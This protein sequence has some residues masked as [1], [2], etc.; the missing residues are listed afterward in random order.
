MRE[1]I[2]ERQIPRFRGVTH[3]T[4]WSCYRQVGIEKKKNYYIRFVVHKYVKMYIIRKYAQRIIQNFLVSP[5]KVN[6]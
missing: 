5:K 6:T 4:C 2:W 3:D 1:G